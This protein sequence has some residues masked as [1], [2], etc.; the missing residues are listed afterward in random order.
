MYEKLYPGRQ[1]F[2]DLAFT[3]PGGAPNAFRGFVRSPDWPSNTEFM[4]F[5]G[6]HNAEMIERVLIPTS[7][8][9]GRGV[10]RVDAENFDV[11]TEIMLRQWAASHYTP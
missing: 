1:A 2:V 5:F 10:M 3:K 6:R 11:F 7:E 4:K 9:G 8:C